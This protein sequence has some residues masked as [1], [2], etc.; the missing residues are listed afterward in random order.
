MPPRKKK[1]SELSGEFLVVKGDR[2][3]MVSSED[4]ASVT[5]DSTKTTLE[6][7]RR[8][9]VDKL[10][11]RKAHSEVAVNKSV[12]LNAC[13]GSQG[14]MGPPWS[15]IGML[16]G[17]K[18]ML[19]ASQA[20]SVAGETVGEEGVPAFVA[21]VASCSARKAAPPKRK[22]TPIEKMKAITKG[23]LSSAVGSGMNEALFSLLIESTSEYEALLFSLVAENERL[24]GR[25]EVL[26]D[27][28]RLVKAPQMPAPPVATHR[29]GPVSTVS[30]TPEMPRPVETWSLVVRSRTAGKTAKDVV[31]QV[32]KEVG[33]TL[34]VRVHEVKPLRDGGAII[35]TPSVAE[36]R[37]IAE[38]AK[39]SEVGLDVSVNEKLGPKVVIHGVHSQ[40]TPDE[41]M[42]DLHELNLKDKM[43]LESFKKEVKMVSK[44]WA[45]ATDGA[46]N[47]VLEG[48]GLAMQT[49]L[50]VGRCYVKWFSFRVRSYD[51]VVGCF[52]CLGF[53]HKVAECR[54]KEDVC[55][56]CGQMGHRVAQCSNALNCRN[57]AFKGK[58]SDHLMMSP[59]CPVY[60]AIVARANARH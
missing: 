22:G 5:S 49:L 15:A 42:S 7:R 1:A 29:R 57:C 39:F 32:V 12:E 37:K 34:G 43:S 14:D 4:D 51:P 33:P 60:G 35:R 19:A 21:P 27:Q 2:E 38:N 20:T 28:A 40:I 48:A 44:P 23:V 30:S 45:A 58:P 24:K 53:D 56:R 31:E 55:R 11:L 3:G 47:V 59:A 17:E 16:E 25:L 46:V 8:G 26:E 52:R 10:R 9:F 54:A 36:R 13:G 18:Q 6:N 41:F 50:D